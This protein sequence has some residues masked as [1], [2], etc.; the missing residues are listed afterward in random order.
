[1]TLVFGTAPDSWGVWFPNDD[2][3]PPWHRFLDESAAA[4]YVLIELGPYGYLPTD[5]EILT[6]E[7]QARGLAVVAG[8]AVARL[9]DAESRDETTAMIDEVARLVSAVGGRFLVLLQDAYRDPDGTIKGSREL[10]ARA[11]GDLVQSLEHA[12]RLVRDGYGLSLVFHPHA[13]TPVETPTQVDRLLEDTDPA[14]VS[15]CLDT[16]HYEWYGGDTVDIFER[17]AER[18]PYLHLK[19]IQPDIVARVRSEDLPFAEAVT[20]G[21]VCEPDVGGVDFPALA[22]AMARIGYRGAAVVEQDMY[23]LEDL[24]APL[25]IASRTRRYFETLGWTTNVDELAAG[26]GHLS[27]APREEFT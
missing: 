9:D 8:T 21:G 17:Y 10:G 6:E 20:L 2:R 27:R 19:S 25:P 12:G 15:L 16:G 14:L 22:A 11:W 3:Q 24:A 26:A 4:G 5:P 1:M 7:L 13:D 23:P 18:I